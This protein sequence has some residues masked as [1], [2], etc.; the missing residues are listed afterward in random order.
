MAEPPAKRARR[1]DSAAMWDRTSKPSDTRDKP[2]DSTKG[3][4][5]PGDRS[6]EERDN[7]DHRHGRDEPSRRSLSPS[8][9]RT[10][11]RDRERR[12]ERSRSRDKGLGRPVNGDRSRSRT[13]GGKRRRDGE[14]RDRERSGSG[15]RQR[16]RRGESRNFCVLMNTADSRLAEDQRAVSRD[17]HQSRR[18]KCHTAT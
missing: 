6:R 8:G 11:D 15:E 2:Q 18:S 1:T 7:R 12:K 9:D 10:R 16:S 14:R 3:G 5:R 13:R 17:K 4:K